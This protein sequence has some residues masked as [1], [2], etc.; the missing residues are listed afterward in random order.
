MKNRCIRRVVLTWD[1]FKSRACLIFL[2]PPGREV[3]CMYFGKSF[4]ALKLDAEEDLRFHE[5][6]DAH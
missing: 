1:C 2:F 6:Y 5:F 3:D 4:R